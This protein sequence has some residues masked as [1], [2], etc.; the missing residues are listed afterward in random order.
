MSKH[1]QWQ[2]TQGNSIP[3]VLLHCFHAIK[4]SGMHWRSWE[5]LR[6]CH[7]HVGSTGRSRDALF[8]PAAYS[9]WQR[10]RQRFISNQ[11]WMFE[12]FLTTSTGRTNVFTTETQRFPR[13]PMHTRRFNCVKA[14]KKNTWN[15]VSLRLLPLRVSQRSQAVELIAV[16]IASR[17]RERGRAKPGTY[18]KYISQRINDTLFIFHDTTRFELYV[19]FIR[20]IP[21]LCKNFT[22]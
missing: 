22:P 16:V 11:R 21:F 1:A 13:A 19:R 4:A 10:G 15:R 20:S 6:F 14:V 3:S 12:S 5:A 17:E 2:E 18:V 8:S 7:E 9:W